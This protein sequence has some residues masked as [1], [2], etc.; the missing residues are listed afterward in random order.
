MR[1]VLFLSDSVNRRF[2][3]FYN[4]SGLKL[5]NLER[6]AARSII[7]D[8]HYCG[9]APCMPARRDIMTGRLNFLERSWG[10]IEAIDYTLP[11][12]LSRGGIAS[13]IVTDHYHYF[14]L[15]GQNY[16]QRFGTWELVRGQEND[17]LVADLHERDMPPHLGTMKQQTLKNQALWQHNPDAQP[18]PVVITHAAA[19]LEAHHDVDNWLLW[20]EAFDPHEPF[21]VPQKYLDM[22]G[23][24]YTGPLY[25]WP[26]YKRVV[27][28]KD[29]DEA[30]VRHA[31]KRYMALLYM[32]DEYIGK[33]FDVMDRHNM[34]QDTA[35]I[36]TT[37][38]GYM[39]GEH[40]Y[41]AKN[42]MPAYN[43]VFNIPLMLHL[44]GDEGAGKRIAALTQNID[45]LPT[46][47]D[48]YG[49]EQSVLRSP[50]HGKS[51]LPLV[52]GEVDKVREAA[53]YG[54]FGKEINVTD[55][56]YTLMRAPNAENRPLNLYTTS[57]SENKKLFD[58]SDKADDPHWIND[59][60]KLSMGRF[61]PWT[62]Y[63][64]YKI[65]A[66]AVVS[67]VGPLNYV[68]LNPWEQEDYLFDMQSDP[69]QDHN[70]AQQD[71]LLMEKMCQL[72]K[73]TMVAHDAP[74][75]QFERMRLI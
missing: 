75:E 28:A 68:T 39:L 51:L 60:M 72:L 44:P 9:S 56:H 1:S 16:C 61:L 45:L 73:Q 66:D 2:M 12:V 33:I 35:F 36:Y 58:Y 5:P 34:W 70:L 54:Y 25:M 55:G 17:G 57:L 22:V 29:I 19:W 6:L 26:E 42:Y 64:V 15:G 62:Q 47:M 37:D 21:D 27:D 8:G 24:D 65:P 32:T 7:F 10:P 43:E 49:I 74:A 4:Q 13:H 41:L 14:E 69:A 38:H 40:G 50:I 23:D 53:L 59:P 31:R 67:H 20:V 30:A 46:L 48:L 11:Q 3:E 63:P 52:R 71:P 18:S